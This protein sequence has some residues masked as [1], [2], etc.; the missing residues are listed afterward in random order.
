MLFLLLFSVVFGKTENITIFSN[1]EVDVTV[2]VNSNWLEKGGYEFELKITP[3][4]DL[5][6]DETS[7]FPFF[8]FPKMRFFRR[9]ANLLRH[10]NAN[11][12]N[13]TRNGRIA[14]RTRFGAKL[15]KLYRFSISGN[16]SLSPKMR[17]AFK[18]RNDH[19][20][21]H[22]KSTFAGQIGFFWKFLHNSKFR[23]RNWRRRSRN[24][25]FGNH[26]VDSKHE[27]YK[28]LVQNSRIR[29]KSD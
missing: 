16:S 19:L 13:S 25:I 4:N 9:L 10:A 23:P 11:R 28:C 12:P 3:S 5:I 15:P 22:S 27:L 24:F 8:L 20:Q 7:K 6:K 2:K 17:H 29:R 18:R 1:P 26:I 21:N 14:K